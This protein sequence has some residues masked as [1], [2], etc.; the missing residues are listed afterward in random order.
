MKKITLLLLILLTAAAVESYA[1][2]TV[3]T[4]ACLL[5]EFSQSELD[6]MS[7]DELSYQKFF[8]ENA[9]QVYPVPEDKPKDIYPHKKWTIESDVCIYDM[10][11]KVKAD[12][13]VNFFSKNNKLVMIYSEKELKHNYE[14]N[15]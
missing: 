10:K 12:E 7:A 14:K 6:A 3:D 1:Q 11:V 4:D 9:V 5:N 2:S 13:R 8:V 15:K